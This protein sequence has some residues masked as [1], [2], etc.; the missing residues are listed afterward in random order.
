MA[1]DVEEWYDEDGE[2]NLT[3]SWD[4]NDPV[5]S[6]FNDWTDEDFLTAITNACDEREQLSV[7]RKIL[8]DDDFGMYSTSDT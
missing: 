3:I 5:E 8:P 7:G 2:L 4:E 6:Q 1:I